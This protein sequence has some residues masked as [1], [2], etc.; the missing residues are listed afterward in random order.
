[1]LAFYRDVL[2]FDVEVHDVEGQFV[3]L[4]NA[5]VRFQ[6]L[7]Q[8]TMRVASGHDGFG[9]PRGGHSF[10][11]AFEVGTPREVDAHYAKILAGGGSPI[12]APADKPWG[13]RIAFFADPDG[14]IHD[15]YAT[16]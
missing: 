9:A 12:A 14:N 6:L 3:Q 15:V 10:E 13:Q 5:G 16:L 1:M 4:R 8:E 11:L 2:G 7:A